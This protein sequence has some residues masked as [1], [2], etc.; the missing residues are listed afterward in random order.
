MANSRH[1]LNSDEKTKA[2]KDEEATNVMK[3]NCFRNPQPEF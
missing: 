1:T 3:L 2:V